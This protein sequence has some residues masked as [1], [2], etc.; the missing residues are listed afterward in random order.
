MLTRNDFTSSTGRSVVFA[1]VAA[2]ALT[3]AG[4]SFAGTSAKGMSATGSSSGITDFSARAGIIIIVIAASWR[5]R[6]RGGCGIC[7][8][9]G[10]VGAIA[11]SQSRRDAYD[12]YGGPAYYARPPGLLRRPAL[13][14]ALRRRVRLWRRR[15][16][17]RSRR[18]YHSL[19][20]VVRGEQ[21]V[22]DQ[23]AG[24]PAA[25]FRFRLISAVNTLAMGFR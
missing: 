15:Q 2:I 25:W 8:H 12:Y 19:L 21:A 22:P 16:L 4:P 6:C 3:A 20:T 13:C 24:N 9:H 23:A 1:T 17:P 5:R 10:T 11:A 14:V 7:R 18:E